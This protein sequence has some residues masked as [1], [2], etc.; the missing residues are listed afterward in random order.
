MIHAIRKLAREIHH[1]SVWQ[2][3][4]VYLAMGWV[5]LQ[6]VEL[7]TDRIGLPG[8]TPTMA[9]VLMALV[10]P[11]TI[12]TA[13]VQ[14]G[15]PWLRIEDVVDPNELEGLTPE[16]VH[17][18]PEAHPL[19]GEGL[20]TWRNAVLL[21]VLSLALLVTSVVAYLTMWALGIG[22]VGS[23]VAQGVIGVSDPVLLAEFDN[24]TDDVSLGP[25]LTDA[26]E[27]D[28]SE[29]QLVSLVDELRIAEALVRMGYESSTPV[30]S[31]IA[32]ELA[33]AEGIKVLV[34][35][36]IARFGSG[37]RLSVRI[38]LPPGT[39]PVSEFRETVAGDEDLVSAIDVLSERVRAKFGESLRVIRSGSPLV[40][41]YGPRLGSPNSY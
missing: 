3:L 27:A 38:V 23:L 1:R 30:T 15:L 20:F 19:Y 10:L 35:G 36:D 5:G 17:V 8:W 4:G 13:A 37:Y 39:S 25:A 22:P 2:V 31:A 24:R 34:L 41:L 6:G 21:G 14:G 16:E 18:V 40:E 29:S 11:V 9:I 32:R 26:F 12:A 28:L 33:S 7:L